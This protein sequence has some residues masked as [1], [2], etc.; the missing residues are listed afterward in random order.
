M[1]VLCGALQD[2]ALSV[3]VSAA[4]AAANVADALQQQQQHLSLQMALH[5]S[6][7][8]SGTAACH[9][10]VCLYCD[11]SCKALYA[12]FVVGHCPHV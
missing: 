12:C 4:S 6:S 2:P 5:L 1:K 8:A 9:L 3:R 11:M 10:C 7:L